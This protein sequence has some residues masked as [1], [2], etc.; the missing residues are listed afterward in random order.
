MFT[1]IIATT[2][3]VKLLESG[4]LI[5]KIPELT[6]E[7]RIG[8][9]VAISGVCLTAKEIDVENQ[10]VSFDV[11]E[12][13]LQRTT[14]GAVQAGQA[15]NIELALAAGDRL[16]GH[17]VQGHIDAMGE[18]V[19]IEDQDGSHRFRF[20]VGSE[21]EELIV[22]KGSIAVDGISLT[23]FNISAGAFDTAIIPHT[24]SVTTLKSLKPGD[25]VNIEFDIVG[26][27]IKKQLR[28]ET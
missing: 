27:Y 10:A 4:R 17:W 20:R 22:E 18:V 14:L 3:E 19:E 24:L 28:K 9:S 5:V 6:A 26:K 23:P 13:T 11:S 15:V 12:E 25:K 2:G 16:G 7:I 8:D 21:G 1:G